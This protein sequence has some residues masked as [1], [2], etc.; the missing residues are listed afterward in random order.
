M[1]KTEQFLTLYR[2]YEG[3]LRDHG[4]D[5]KEIE[6]AADDTAQNRMRITRQIRNYL[7]HNADPMFLEVSDQQIRLLE[8]LIKEEQ[9]EGDIL[10]N[11]LYTVKKAACEEGELVEDVLLRMAKLKM[12]ELLAIQDGKAVGTVNMYKLLIQYLKD[13]KTKIGKPYGKNMVCFPPEKPVEAVKQYA[14]MNNIL[15]CTSDGTQNGKVIGIWKG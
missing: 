14:G 15:C 5:Y 2:T 13:K 8:T 11:H 6:D 12:E 10:K 1:T 4:K 9:M 3:L 7:S